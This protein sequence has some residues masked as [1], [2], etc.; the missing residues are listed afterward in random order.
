MNI[1]IKNL[2]KKIALKRRFLRQIKKAIRRAWKSE[3]RK[4]RRAEITLCLVDNRRIRKLNLRYLGRDEPTDVLA[5]NLGAKRKM[6]VA[7]II[8]SAQGAS[9]NARR[10]KTNLSYE[11]LLYAV[12]GIL[13]IL[14][15]SDEN[16]RQK[17]IMHS[18][19]VKI[20]AIL[21]CLSIKAKP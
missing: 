17:K 6:L 1:V 19:A 4:D 18:K 9:V 13:H 10:F 11:L 15:Y 2:Q 16:S 5:F 12:H 3:C 20:L 8:V 14:G 7:D 21:P